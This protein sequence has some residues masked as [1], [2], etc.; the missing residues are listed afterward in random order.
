[1]V[2]AEKKLK[3]CH[4]V[5]RFDYGGLEKLLVDMINRLPE[6]QFEH[7]IVVL[8]EAGSIKNQ[9][10]VPVDLYEFNKQAGHDIQLYRRIYQLF[11]RIRPDI[12]HSYNL[13]A[14]EFQ[15]LACFAGVKKRIHAEHGRDAADPEG[16]NKRHRVLRKMIDPFISC[17]V[18]VSVDLKYW[19]QE[20]IGIR[21]KKIVFIRNG[22]DTNHFIPA[23]VPVDSSKEVHFVNVA[24]LDPVKNHRLLL[25]AFQELTTK[26]PNLRLSIAGEGSLRQ[27]LQNRI[28]HSGLTGKVQLL[29]SVD[30]VV[31][32]YQQSSVFVLTS[33]AE[34]TPMTVLEA[35]SCGLPVIAT[36]V[37]GVADLVEDQ[38][39]GYL[40]D[41]GNREQLEKKMQ[42]Y[43]CKPELRERHGQIARETAVRELDAT[44]ADKEYINLYN[45]D[46]CL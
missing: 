21:H 6:D 3:I 28:D 46:D 36:R 11:R 15:A 27:E 22:I 9:L 10:S 18:A 39:T 25:D 40:V 43:I 20:F 7:A 30:Q 37:G 44:I 35:M 14:L 29:G 16:K 8:T 42:A 26:H 32:L 4:I 34:G 12:T 19:L 45:R 33:V 38:V 17:Y 31:K 1:M 2:T 41:S 5:Y 24:R 23:Q 13:A